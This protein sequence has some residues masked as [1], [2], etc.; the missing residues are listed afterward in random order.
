MAF[1]EQVA[2]GYAKRMAAEPVRF[3]RI[4]A[5]QAPEA[6]GRD[7]LQAV[8]EFELDVS[9]IHYDL[10]SIEFFGAYEQAVAPEPSPSDTASAQA[11]AETGQAK[12]APQPTY[13]RS[14]SGRKHV[15]QIQA[16]INVTKFHVYRLDPVTLFW[17]QIAEVPKQTKS[18]S[19]PALGDGLDHQYKV[20][21][22][23][24]F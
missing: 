9:Q 5:N 22:V 21:A 1:F 4:H 13:G 11:P 10:T 23:I 24:K 14:K 8:R 3:A 17:T 15:K 16:G 6:V 20:T 18:Y 12:S 2:G 19:D 7:V